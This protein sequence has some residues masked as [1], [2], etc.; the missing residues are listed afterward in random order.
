[1]QRFQFPLEQALKWRATRLELENAKLAQLRQEKENARRLCG[2]ISEAE[3][4][5]VAAFRQGS[6]NVTGAELTL[7]ASYRQGVARR[8]KKLEL[9]IGN[10]EAAIEKQKA[11]VLEADREK[12]LLESLKQRQLEEWTYEFN[13]EIENTAAELYLANQQRARRG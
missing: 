12:R 5:E 8:L 2:N 13:R 11:A 4:R 3:Q 7:L 9:V 10:C 1:M 6:R